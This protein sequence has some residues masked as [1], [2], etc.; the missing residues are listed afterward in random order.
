MKKLTIFAGVLSCALAHAQFIVDDFTSGAYS[1]TLQ[2]GS[3]LAFQSG[4]MAGGW[5]G[6][7]MEVES[8]PLNH[9][10]SVSISGGLHVTNSDTLVDGLV[11]LHYGFVSDGG[12]GM[13]DNDM[14]LDFSNLDRFR[15]KFLTNDRDLHVTI[16][17]H[18]SSGMSSYHRVVAGGQ[19]SAFEE[20][21]MFASFAGSG[22]FNDVD[23]V[24]F[25]FDSLH[26]GDYALQSIEAVPE[27]A[28]LAVIG[29]GLAA[30][31]RRRRK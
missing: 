13:S 31:V 6:V 14:N 5:R 18:S 15:M 8:N 17:V 3:S 9:N 1:N 19:F 11:M 4:S 26:S 30:L 21:F 25:V 10:F 28:S 24:S 2:S 20:D 7:Y 12:G 23:R 16:N 27:P 29:L 22:S